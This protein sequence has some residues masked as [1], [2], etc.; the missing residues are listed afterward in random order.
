MPQ[1]RSVRLF[2]HGAGRAG[3][4]AWP[5]VPDGDAVFL[6]LTGMSAMRERVLA[7]AEAART[8]DTVIAH[9]AGAVPVALA[10]A[11]GLIS[12]RLLVLLE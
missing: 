9:S 3:R 4:A 8:S 12:P 6:D 2:V 11:E 5:A 7:I 1:A 10:A